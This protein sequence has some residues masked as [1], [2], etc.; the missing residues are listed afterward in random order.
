MLML[1]YLDQC[2]GPACFTDT[3][4]ILMTTRKTSK[5]QIKR[6][7]NQDSEINLWL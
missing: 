4:K 6:V 3:K 7:T 1:S 2:L 5:Y